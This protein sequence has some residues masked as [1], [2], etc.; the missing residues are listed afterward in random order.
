MMRRKMPISVSPEKMLAFSNVL[1][2]VAAVLTVIATFLVIYFG[3]RVDSK[4]QTELKTYQ[5]NAGKEVSNLRRQLN[6]RTLSPEQFKTIS[7]GL[8][9]LPQRKA[10]IICPLE[11]Q[12]SYEYA[13]QLSRV[14]EVAHWNTGAGIVRQPKLATDFGI[15]IIGREDLREGVQSLMY[16]LNQASVPASMNI[17]QVAL[18]GY[19]QI[20]VGP[21]P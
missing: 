2:V 8:R 3:N 16:V 14:L 18:A 11:N 15:T 9:S 4:K 10:Q 20:L 7:V 19:I 21:K 5:E 1:L 6:Y 12:E 13:K 17:S